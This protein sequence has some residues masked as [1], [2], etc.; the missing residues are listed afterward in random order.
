MQKIT[1]D[2]LD[3]QPL[4]QELAILSLQNSL[5]LHCDSYILYQHKSF[6]S[7][8]FMSVM[9]LEE[10]GKM[11]I[12]NILAYLAIIY[13]ENEL[14]KD[15][16]FSWF[17]KIYSHTNKQHNS[18]NY[19]A[20]YETVIKP[21]SF[22]KSFFHEE[23]VDKESI[24]QRYQHILKARYDSKKQSAMYVGIEEDSDSYYYAT[25]PVEEITKSLA[26]N[27]I[28][29]VQELLM[30]DILSVKKDGY[31]YDSRLLTYYILKHGTRIYNKLK[32]MNIPISKECQ[33][34]FIAK[35]AKPTLTKY[36]FDS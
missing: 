11:K 6:P 36:D 8:Y 23:F 12:L 19:G 21:N 27:Q 25:N 15:I 22:L 29:I 35:E 18:I 5:R 26:L 33:Q 14:Q 30:E 16:I 9:A 7:A 10:L 17:K 32:S 20:F 3:D 1:K 34:R 31:Y 28:A 13:E 4:M 2:I 24:P